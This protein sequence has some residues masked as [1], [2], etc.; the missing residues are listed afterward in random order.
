MGE[1]D[2]CMKEEEI[3]GLYRVRDE[4]I[5][6]KAGD[7]GFASR[8]FPGEEEHYFCLQGDVFPR[9]RTMKRAVRDPVT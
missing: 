7:T 3:V 6:L 8:V 4:K 2:T 1:G 9:M 5:V